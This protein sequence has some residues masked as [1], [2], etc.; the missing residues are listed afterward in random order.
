MKIDID[1]GI[2]TMI[3]DGLRF[4]SDMAAPPVESYAT[5]AQ[6]LQK[7]LDRDP[8]FTADPARY[9]KGQI[10]IRPVHRGDGFKTR[11]DRLC[12]HL[13]G[14]WSNREHALHH[15]PF[16]GR[17]AASAVQR[18]PRRIHHHEG[19][20]PAMNLDR[21]TI[22]SYAVTLIAIGSWMIVAARLVE[23]FK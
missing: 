11:A 7:H 19:A 21:T 2:L 18:R 17:E 15:E 16:E 20:L 1:R 12:E 4:A 5:I 10:A 6:E 14:R 23:L 13:N 3:I 8:G 9:A 22:L